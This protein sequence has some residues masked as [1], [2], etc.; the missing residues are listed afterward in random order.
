V[1]DFDSNSQCVIDGHDR[2]QASWAMPDAGHYV[3]RVD[4]FSLCGRASA[5]WQLSAT[6]DGNPLA[7]TDGIS[8]VEDTYGPHQRGS[9]LTALELDVPS[10]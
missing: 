1:L 4:T 3:V 6:L 2:E 8:V 10:P 7:Q 9:G 5:G